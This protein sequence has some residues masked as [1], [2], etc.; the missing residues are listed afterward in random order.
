MQLEP[1][2]SSALGLPRSVSV[3]DRRSGDR[4]HVF[5]PL[6]E[7]ESFMGLWMRWCLANEPM[8]F[9][10]T[11]VLPAADPPWWFIDVAENESFT[12][13]FGL[14]HKQ[15]EV[16]S[17]RL[18]AER[19]HRQR[20]LA[21]NFRCC[22]MCLRLGFHSIVHQHW[23]MT[24]CPLH[25]CRLVLGCPAC[26]E[27]V[28]PS[29]TNCADDP[30]GCPVCRVLWLDRV[31]IARE[32]NSLPIVGSML[33]LRISALVSLQ[34]SPPKG[35]WA[36]L[37]V[38]ALGRDV[39][40][41]V[42]SSLSRAVR[43]WTAWQLDGGHPW[44]EKLQKFNFESSSL[45]RGFF[46]AKSRAAATQCLQRLAVL[47]IS[48]RFHTS[49]LRLFLGLNRP[50]LYFD[51]YSTVVGAA[52]HQTMCA[53]GESSHI[54]SWAE[55]TFSPTF[56]YTDIRWQ[57]RAAGIYPMPD[58]ALAVLI[59][60]EILG[61]FCLAVRKLSKIK[62]LQKVDWHGRYPAASYVPAW[63]AR[64]QDG[65]LTLLVRPRATWRTV[66]YLLRRHQSGALLPWRRLSLGRLRQTV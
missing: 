4:S 53:Y 59:E 17:G 8:D 33:Q 42:S 6:A 38:P 22:P 54:E 9:R 14:S 18:F 25:S 58:E 29:I 50:G 19:E 13:R 26:R 52:L 32:Q 65:E 37:P 23:A 61:H 24:T 28:R 46:G 47:C 20:V 62:Y 27:P 16:S 35:R 2:A 36:T 45:P 55:R 5:L 12:R 31:A 63:A 44:P 49:R 3:R 40:G 51:G 34:G 39:G 60:F 30:F 56:P 1:G 57:G 21:R 11:D 10:A 7:T 41:W 66:E 64:Q 48:H 15:S 43:R